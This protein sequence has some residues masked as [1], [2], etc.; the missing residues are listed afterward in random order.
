MTTLTHPADADARPDVRTEAHAH[1]HRKPRS[2]GWLLLLLVTFVVCVGG[3]VA[4]AWTLGGAA[5]AVP[6]TA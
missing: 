5:Y 1:R 6:P 2:V 3:L 4:V